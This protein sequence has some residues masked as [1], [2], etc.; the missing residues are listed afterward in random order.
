[1]PFTSALAGLCAAA[2]TAVVEVVPLVSIVEL[3]SLIAGMYL[4]VC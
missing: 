3:Q 1:L 4:S 2:S